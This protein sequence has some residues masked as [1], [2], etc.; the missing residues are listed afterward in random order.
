MSDDGLG[1]G[2]DVPP[3]APH[4]TERD[5]D[6]EVDPDADGPAAFMQAL[7]VRR[8]AVW[9]VGVGVAVTALVF[10]VFVVIPGTIRSP[11]W[12]L[13]LAFVLALST[14]GLV[15]TVLTLTRAARLSRDL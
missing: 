3:D 9:G 15:A 13:G 8:N 2:E 12:Y 6:V 10:V 14:A 4:G 1:P 5:L 7:R 11:L